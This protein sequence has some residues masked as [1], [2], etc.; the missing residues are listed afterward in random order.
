[1]KFNF[2]KKQKEYPFFWK[3][4]LSKLEYQV[5]KDTPINQ[6]SFV[7]FDTETS[8]FDPKKDKLL[9]IGAVRVKNNQINLKESFE[10]RI[11]QEEMYN[12]STISV[13]G[14]IPNKEKGIPKHEAI[15][16]FIDYLGADIIVGQNITFDIAIINQGLRPIVNEKLKNRYVDTAKLARRADH[17]RSP[18]LMK[19]AE[20]TLD[21]LCERYKIPMHD[22]HNAAGDALLTAL[23]FMKLLTQLKHRGVKTLKDLI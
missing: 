7:V 11:L 4:Y 5:N 12:N 6:L 2:W 8:G 1:M 10:V 13:H 19:P 9:T 15:Q 23:L 3:N 21:A 20:F 18:E 22:R 16:Q 17:L 14:I